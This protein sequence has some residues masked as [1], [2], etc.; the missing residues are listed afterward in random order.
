M[1]QPLNLFAGGGRNGRSLVTRLRGVIEELEDGMDCSRRF[2]VS[3]REDGSSLS[4][5]D[6]STSDCRC[7]LP[8]R[9]GGLGNL[10]RSE[11]GPKGTYFAGAA[12]EG[13]RC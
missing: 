11:C 3:S 4:D 2:R 9:C 13:V 8:G 10:G 6:Q 7:R 5:E 1:Y 12:S